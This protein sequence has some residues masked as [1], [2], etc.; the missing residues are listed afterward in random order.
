[1]NTMSNRAEGC[2]THPDD[3][4]ILHLARGTLESARALSVHWHLKSCRHCIERLMQADEKWGVLL[5]NT[6]P[7]ELN[8][9][10][11]EDIKSRIADLESVATTQEL[12]HLL[13]NVRHELDSSIYRVLE[14]LER[15]HHKNIR[16]SFLW[17]G[18]RYRTLRSAENT[19]VIMQ[20]K[21]GAAIPKHSYSRNEYKLVLSGSYSDE[22]GEYKTGDFITYQQGEQHTPA[23]NTDQECVLVAGELKYLHFSNPL[24]NFFLHVP[25]TMKPG[26]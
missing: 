21:P 25:F 16:W 24:A 12:E 1:M 11:R 8:P 3:S 5:E 20:I 23:N 2:F 13:L 9:S 22:Y 7:V 6:D 14:L 10:A 26:I 19:V 18:S 17:K 4:L 15:G